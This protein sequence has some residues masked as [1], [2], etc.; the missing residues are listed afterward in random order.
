MGR[1]LT[2]RSRDP[3]LQGLLLRRQRL[4]LLL[5]L[6]F[7]TLIV[8]SRWRQRIDWYGE[9]PI[10]V[11]L[12]EIVPPGAEPSNR[13]MAFNGTPVREPAPVDAFCV[14]TYFEREFARYSD[15]PMAR[16]ELRRAGPYPL[17]L[18]PPDVGDPDASLP[19]LMW[20]NLQYYQYFEGVAADL[21]LDF[22]DYDVRM[23][24]VL[25]GDDLSGQIEAGS[26]ASRSKRFGVVFLDM[27]SMDPTYSA[28]TL[29][30]E[31]GHAFGAT[32]KYDLDT[33][34]AVW[35]QGYADPLLVPAHPQEYAELMAGDI[36]LAADDEREISSLDEVQ[37]GVQTA[38]EIGWLGE[39]KRFNYYR[40]LRDAP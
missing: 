33:Y 16:V 5:F 1:T 19:T 23:V 17:A 8:A 31:I 32:D 34:H 18:A 28:L 12:L 13:F 11:L 6:S 22:D 30:H 25:V 9:A 20:R 40:A 21:G 39:W 29:L 27:H 14:E 15:E 2:S 24:A 37:I 10:R 3:G 35:P 4:M 38:H 26:M 7:L 36:P